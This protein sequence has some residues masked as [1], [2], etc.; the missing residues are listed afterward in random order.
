MPSL[1]A[2]KE[3]LRDDSAAMAD[4]K[5]DRLSLDAYAARALH[6]RR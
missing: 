1:L 5:R 6:T 2:F 4:K 3:K